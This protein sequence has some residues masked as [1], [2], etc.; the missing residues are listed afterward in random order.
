MSVIP[1]PTQLAAANAEARKTIEA[2][3]HF[4]SAMIPDS[5]LQT[6]VKAALTAAL[7]VPIV[8]KKG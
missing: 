6:V 5:A 4:D 2:Y 1:T 8:P 7:N 3:S